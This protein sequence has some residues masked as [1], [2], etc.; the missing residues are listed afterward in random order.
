MTSDLREMLAWSLFV[1]TAAIAWPS[2]L[3]IWASGFCIAM[4]VSVAID[5]YFER[6]ERSDDA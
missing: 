2:T 4:S 6:A 1:T 5:A 3:T